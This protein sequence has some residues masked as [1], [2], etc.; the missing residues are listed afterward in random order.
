MMLAAE[1][2]MRS[3]SLYAHV[4]CI[5]GLREGLTRPGDAVDAARRRHGQDRRRRARRS[6]VRALADFADA[7][8]GLYAATLR[9]PGDSAELTEANQ[10]T[11]AADGGA[12]LVRSGGRRPRPPL[13]G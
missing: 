3:Q 6:V 4:A 1:L 11:V 12:R 7:H 9:P 8:P 5:E 10:R 2:G 13:P